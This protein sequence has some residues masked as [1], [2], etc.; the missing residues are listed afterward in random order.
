[1]PP[2]YQS[3]VFYCQESQC[4]RHNKIPVSKLDAIVELLGDSLEFVRTMQASLTPFN[5]KKPFNI[6]KDVLLKLNGGEDREAWREVGEN[7]TRE[8]TM[9]YY[10]SKTDE[11]HYEMTYHVH[12]L[13]AGK[14]QKFIAEIRVKTFPIAYSFDTKAHSKS[15]MLNFF[16]W[17]QQGDSAEKRYQDMILISGLDYETN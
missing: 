16:N 5:K 17:I 7:G 12:P 9:T 11:N 1:M 6:H 13:V 2:A 10:N 4:W 8:M 15:I 14:N 3:D